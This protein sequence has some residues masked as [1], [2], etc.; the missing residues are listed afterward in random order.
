MT[1]TQRV[2]SRVQPLTCNGVR[3]QPAAEGEDVKLVQPGGLFQKLPAVWTETCVQHR[4]TSAQLE[5]KD[6]LQGR[7]RG[8]EGGGGVPRPPTCLA[9]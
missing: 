1:L 6:A 9:V 4:L 5:V 8:Q 7:S 2:K 3:I